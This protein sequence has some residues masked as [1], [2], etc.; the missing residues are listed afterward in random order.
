M[1][2]ALF[3]LATVGLFFLFRNN[4]FQAGYREA[5][6]GVLFV[7]FG[8][9]FLYP[10][11]RARFTWNKTVGR[12]TN[13]DHAKERIEFEFGVDGISYT[14]SS[15]SD[16]N[17]HRFGQE[18]TV[19]FDAEDPMKNWHHSWSNEMLFGWG[20]LALGICTALFGSKF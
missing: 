11:L 10:N 8:V 3:I 15:G 18:I 7:A 20:V 19:Y 6:G 16:P 2:K 9:Y 12:V 5:V 1:T 13:L 14:G 4:L 17:W